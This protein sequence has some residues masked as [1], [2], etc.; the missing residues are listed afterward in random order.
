MKKLTKSEYNKIIQEKIL[1]T[2]DY[3]GR[4][5]SDAEEDTELYW[6][7]MDLKTDY[8]KGDKTLINADAEIAL[9]FLKFA[10]DDLLAD[11]DDLYG[12]YT[13]N[14]QDINNHFRGY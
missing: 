14:I 7:L 13:E 8:K 5:V 12:S 3:K 6:Y 9:N 4:L 11:I 2:G 10:N 1:L